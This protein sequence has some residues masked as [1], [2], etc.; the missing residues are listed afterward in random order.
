MRL[1]DVK[2]GDKFYHYVGDRMYLRID[3]NPSIMFKH[4]QLP[5]DTVAALDLSTY[6][7]VCLNGN[8]E[9]EVKHDNVFI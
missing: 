2:I 8:Y 9:V 5:Y 4:V 6:K 1:S 7:V 3:M